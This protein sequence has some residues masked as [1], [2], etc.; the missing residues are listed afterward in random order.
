MIKYY[1]NGFT[2]FKID[3]EKN[4]VISV[5]NHPENKGIVYSF[6]SETMAESM[7][8]SFSGQLGVLRPGG[9]V[10]TEVTG[11]EYLLARDEVVEHL[12]SA[13]VNL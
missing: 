4:E 9:V 12:T 1:K 2:I 8:D 6:G 10:T 11:E 7:N 13:G 5:T 3:M